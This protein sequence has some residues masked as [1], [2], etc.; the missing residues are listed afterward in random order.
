MQKKIGINLVDVE[1]WRQQG[2]LDKVR[3]CKDNV[4]VSI[5]NSEAYH[6]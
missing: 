6:K 1:H 3:H 4:E 2:F 5:N